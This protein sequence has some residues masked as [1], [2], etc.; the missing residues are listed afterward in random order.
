MGPDLG[1]ITMFVKVNSTDNT[2][3][4][5]VNVY[6]NKS[7]GKSINQSVNQ[8]INN[9]NISYTSYSRRHVHPMGNPK[10]S[11]SIITQSIT[12]T[13]HVLNSTIRR[14]VH[15]M[16]NPKSSQSINQLINQSFTPTSHVLLLP[17]DIFIRR[18]TQRAS[19]QLPKLLIYF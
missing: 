8:S 18:T 14:H 13:S 9:Q 7:K 19:N 10:S 4:Q 1:P 3:R 16:G 2:G 6:A 17:G 12:K 11:R 15:Q 5:S